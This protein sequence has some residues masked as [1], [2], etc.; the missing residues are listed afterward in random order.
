MTE[1]PA[2][3]AVPPRDRTLPGGPPPAGDGEINPLNLMF[4]VGL[5]VLITVLAR[6]LARR[7]RK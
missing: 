6:I 5:A 7:G 2:G 3:T 4:V 1:L